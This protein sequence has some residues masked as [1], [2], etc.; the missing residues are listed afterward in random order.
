MSGLVENHLYYVSDN[1]I[2]HR[3]YTGQYKTVYFQNNWM[4]T[5]V[6]LYY[7]FDD[8]SYDTAAFPGSLMTL[9]HNDGKYDIYR[10]DIPSNAKA[11]NING[12]KNDGSGNMDQTPNIDVSS[13]S[14]DYFYYMNYNNGNEVKLCPR[15]IYLVPDNNWK[16]GSARFAAYFFND[17]TGKNTWVSMTYDS[18]KQ[19]YKCNVPDGEWE[20]MIFCRMNPSAS[21]NNWDNK[22]NQTP[23][24]PIPSDGKNCGTIKISN[25]GNWDGSTTVTW[26]T[27]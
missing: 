11:F 4:W 24:L 8:G 12:I 20:A 6:S 15:I 25:S 19:A 3:A 16:Q 14:P 9:D 2:Q 21:A 26:S 27:K 7:W 13:A 17:T 5:N 10:F 22:W 18:T 1:E 23:D